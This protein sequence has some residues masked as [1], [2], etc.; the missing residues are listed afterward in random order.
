[1][2]SKRIS[3]ITAV[4][5]ALVFIT[6]GSYY[7]FAQR[8]SALIFPYEAERDRAELIEI[9]KQNWFWLTTNPDEQDAVASFA[10]NLDTRSSSDSPFERG[11]LTIMV[12]R[13]NEATKGFIAYH[14]SSWSS[15]KI[16]YLVVNEQYRKAGYAKALMQY[17]LDDLKY[18]NYARVELL[19]RVCNVRAK[20][21]YK[22]FGFVSNWSDEQYITYE[23]TL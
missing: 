4:V 20:G 18:Q 11:N 2:T 9:F 3:Q 6:G 12:Y 8:T 23:K 14:R 21:L 19:T 5:L 17:A 1:M 13:D 15:A 22:K 10:R 7:W 16:L